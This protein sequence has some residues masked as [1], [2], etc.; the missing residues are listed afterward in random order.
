MFPSI[1]TLGIFFI[2]DTVLETSTQKIAAVFA[3]AALNLFYWYTVGP[4]LGQIGDALLLIDWPAGVLAST[5]QIHTG[6]EWAIQAMIGTLSVVWLAR[7]L[8]KERQFVEQLMPATVQASGELLNVHRE[9]KQDRAEITFVP[10]GLVCLSAQGRTLLE[11]AEANDIDLPSGC[12]MGMCGSDPIRVV[13]GG[14]HL[15][16]SSNEEKIPCG[17]WV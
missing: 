1:I 2:L 14:E 11:V 9:A 4:F 17:V 3:A 16:P 15:A 6:F 5:I 10:D 12:R 13:S 7:V 8:V